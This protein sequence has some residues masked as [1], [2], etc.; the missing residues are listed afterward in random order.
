M[1]N[2]TYFI[3]RFSLTLANVW[4][5]VFGIASFS[6]HLGIKYNKMNIRIL[7]QFL[8]ENELAVVIQKLINK[9]W[10]SKLTSNY[11]LSANIIM[12]ETGLQELDCE[13]YA[14]HDLILLEKE[15][16]KKLQHFEV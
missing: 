1:I 12:P 13:G 5:L 6:N 4:C 15:I 7:A 16:S 9:K 8:N 3:Y 2:W 10:A 11:Y 14:D